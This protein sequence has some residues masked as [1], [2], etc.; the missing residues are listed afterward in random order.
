MWFNPYL[1]SH[2]LHGAHVGGH[3]C[4]EVSQPRQA[5]VADL[6]VKGIVDE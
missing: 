3:G 5:E 2:P 6:Y 1:W 4:V